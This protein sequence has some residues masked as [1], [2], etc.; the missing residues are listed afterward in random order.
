MSSLPYYIVVPN[1]SSDQKKRIEKLLR[2]TYNL[3][4]FIKICLTVDPQIRPSSSF[5]LEKPYF[6][7]YELSA[8][9]ISND[10]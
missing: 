10:L 5:L 1:I 9:S 3:K 4:E 7:E 2:S 6:A 8:E